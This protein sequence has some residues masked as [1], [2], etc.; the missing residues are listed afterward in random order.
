MHHPR[1]AT[2]GQLKE[3]GYRPGS[4]KDELR[5]NLIRKL[6]AG[7]ELFP[8]GTRVTPGLVGLAASCGYDTLPVRRPRAAVLVF[9]DELLTRG[10]PGDGRVRDSLGPS[11]PAWLRR[12]SPHGNAVAAGAKG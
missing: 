12:G 4:V 10:L 5:R 9:G 6:R 11:V 8:A 2:V 3:T 1:P 7:E